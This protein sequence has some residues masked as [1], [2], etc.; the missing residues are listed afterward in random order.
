MT[1]EHLNR[2]Q[3][4]WIHDIEFS[5]GDRENLPW[6]IQELIA[7]IGLAPTI[8]LLARF[9][10]GTI[11]LPAMRTSFLPLRNKLIVNQFDGSN[12]NVLAQKFHLGVNYI[13]RLV[14]GN[15]ADNRG[16]GQPKRLNA[17]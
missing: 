17:N 5:E 9:G 8:D 14:R 4:A 10:G 13:Q 16:E 7:T 2:K 1:Q 3:L 6:L 15:Q 12:C 11:Y